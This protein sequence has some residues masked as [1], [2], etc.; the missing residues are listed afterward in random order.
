MEEGERGEGIERGGG[1][2]REQK[3]EKGNDR[4][5]ILSLHLHTWGSEVS[6]NLRRKWHPIQYT[7]FDQ[8]LYSFIVIYC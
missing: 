3:R 5:S 7:T 4:I 6:L 2:E 1:M 8:G